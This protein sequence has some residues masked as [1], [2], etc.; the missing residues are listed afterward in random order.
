MIFINDYRRPNLL[1]F[2]EQNSCYINE[3]QLMSL[4]GK[5]I[6][7]FVDSGGVSGNGFTGI[8]VDVLSD[9]IRLLTSLPSA[10]RNNNSYRHFCEKCSQSSF[11]T[12]TIIMIKHITAITYNQ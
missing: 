8:L 3:L 5:M 11:G 6:I 1:D 10:P 4:K 7:V 12:Y 2:A 9:R